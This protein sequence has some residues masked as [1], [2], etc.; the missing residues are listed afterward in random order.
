M[1]TR[2]YLQVISE[3][4]FPNVTDFHPIPNMLTGEI[5][6]K[7]TVPANQ[8]WNVAFIMASQDVK[9][10]SRA[11][12]PMLFGP[13]M[14]IIGMYVNGVRGLVVPFKNDMHYVLY[15]PLPFNG[16]TEIEI[17]LMPAYEKTRVCILAGGSLVD[18]P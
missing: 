1:A 12:G 5:S 8:I 7:F 6:T 10:W 4:E 9:F 13:A 11:K 3:G 2:A 17:R 16:G 15:D 14:S 18:V